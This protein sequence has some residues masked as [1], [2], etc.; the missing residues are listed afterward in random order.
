MS[1]DRAPVEAMQAV[2]EPTVEAQQPVLAEHETLSGTVLKRLAV[3]GGFAVDDATG[4]KMIQS[5]QG[6]IDSLEARWAKLQ[7]FGQPPKMSRT[8][9]SQW[10][11]NLMLN[12]ATDD[13]GLL[14]QLQTAK[15]ELPNYI[16]AIK[17]AVK[18]YESQD[19]D[20]GTTL[21]PLNAVEA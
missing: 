6:I 13:K 5:L 3:S 1:E 14:T 18:N 11:S 2:V 7:A 4:I 19:S 17:L 10:V 8:A 9:T 16:E 21:K 12:T 20:S 15:A